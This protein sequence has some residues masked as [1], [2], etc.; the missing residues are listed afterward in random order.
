MQEHAPNQ[1]RQLNRSTSSNDM[2]LYEKNEGSISDSAAEPGFDGKKRRGSIAKVAS[3]VGL[4]KKSSST[5]NLSGSGKCKEYQH[6]VKMFCLLHLVLY[7]YIIICF[8]NMY[9]ILCKRISE[10]LYNK[11]V[12]REE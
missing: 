8:K 2:Y 7:C 9:F 1:R 6:S 10:I 3:L 4:S 11:Y 5:S 12:N